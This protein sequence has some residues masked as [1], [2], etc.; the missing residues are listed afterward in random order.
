MGNICCI[1][2]HTY[3]HVCIYIHTVHKPFNKGRYHVKLTF[4]LLLRIVWTHGN[5]SLFFYTMFVY[6]TFTTSLVESLFFGTVFWCSLIKNRNRFREHVSIHGS[7]KKI[8]WCYMYHGKNC[9]WVI[10]VVFSS[11][12]TYTYVF[13]Y[14]Q[15]TSLLIRGGTM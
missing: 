7:Q 9:Q 13:I 1:F 6:Y 5:K 3:I 10:Y 4:S 11:I 2:Q 12:P 14:I 15:Y 8:L